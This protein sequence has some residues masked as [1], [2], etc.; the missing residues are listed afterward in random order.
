[1]ALGLTRDAGPPRLSLTPVSFADLPGWS[2]SDAAAALPALLRSCVRLSQHP[3]APFGS[4]D[5]GVD[6][7]STA[8]WLPSCGEAERLPLGDKSAAR[9]FFEKSFA[10]LAVADYGEREGLFTG[11]FEIELNGSR[12]RH[13]RYQTPIYRRPADLAS[14]PR[15]SRAQIE[16]G[17]LAGRG[18]EL[19]WVDDPIGAFFLQ[20]QGSGRIRLEGGRV[21]RVGYDGQNGLPYVAVGRRLIERGVL[22]RNE[23]SMAAISVWMRA[24]PQAGAALRRENPAFVF[25]RV[26]PGDGPI[27]A[28]RVVLTPEHS[29]AVDRHFIPL[30]VPIWLAASEQFIPGKEVHSLVVAQ[31]TGGAI[32]GP[33]R[34][35]L[36]WG[37]GAAAGARAGVMNARGCYYLLLPRAV[38][39]RLA[40]EE[41]RR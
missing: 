11:Y 10:A 19:F 35:D 29:L 2:D 14:A 31:D 16:D 13:G 41:A 7:G 21:V 8:E 1:V 30:G 6:Y 15:Y 27:G 3:D 34:G 9:R 26:V 23:V 38:G 33:V 18:L 28:E 4:I 37:S 25:F 40:A 20:I 39:M 12:Y 17:A 22:A 5:S 36:F 24:H 32:K